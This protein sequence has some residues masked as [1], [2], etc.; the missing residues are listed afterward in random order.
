MRGHEHSIW[1]RSEQKAPGQM[2]KVAGGSRSRQLT[3]SAACR[4]TSPH[5]VAAAAAGV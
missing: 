1:Y 2:W 5:G 4:L 3:A